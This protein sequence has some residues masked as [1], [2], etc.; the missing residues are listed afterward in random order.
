MNPRIQ[1][2]HTVTEEVTDVDL[3]QA[4]LRIAA[5]ETLADLRPPPGS[6][7]CAAPR[8]SAGSPPRTRPTASARTPADHR[9]PLARA[10]RGIRLDGGTAHTGAEV[11][12]HFD[13]MLVKLTCRGRDFA[14]AVGRARRAVAE[15]RIRGVATNIP[16]LQARPR[17][18]GLPGRP[19]HHVVHRASARSCSPPRRSADRGTRILTYLADVDGQQAARRAAA[20]STRTTSCPAVA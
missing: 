4:Q 7:R 10:A 2:E 3:V 12:A 20:L 19:G 8:C 1:V 18:P 11:C 5:G 16:F 14:T 9:V 15:F 6:S 13:S 17:R